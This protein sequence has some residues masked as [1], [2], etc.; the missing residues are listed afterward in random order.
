MIIWTE[1]VAEMDTNEFLLMYLHVQATKFA[2]WLDNEISDFFQHAA[3]R[4]VVV[5]IRGMWKNG[6]KQVLLSLRQKGESALFFN[7]RK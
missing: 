3:K 4:W 7:Y 2:E 5:S 6:E 1:K